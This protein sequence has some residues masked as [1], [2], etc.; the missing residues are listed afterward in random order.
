[1]IV[2]EN[3]DSQIHE[4]YSLPRWVSVT[5]LP[6]YVI[7][8]LISLVGN[9]AVCMLAVM[10]KRLSNTGNY[11]VLSL[12]LS[13]ILMVILCVPFTVLANLVYLQWVF[14]DFLCPVV[15]YLQLSSVI[16]RSLVLIAAAADRHHAIWRPMRKHATKKTVKIITAAIWIVSLLIPIPTA[17][18]SKLV[19][20]KAGGSEKLC[21][22]VW[23]WENGKFAYGIGMMVVTYAIPLIVLG[24]T[25]GHIVAIIGN[26]PPGERDALRDRRRMD[27]KRKVSG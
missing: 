4:N 24:F 20:L 27:V 13:D 10:K 19:S 1:M 23:P 25:Y 16:Q 3:E 11:F 22:E 7:A 6:L 5:L 26:K 8:T 21:L 17:K 2:N 12:G 9:I 15:G 18:Y 14:G